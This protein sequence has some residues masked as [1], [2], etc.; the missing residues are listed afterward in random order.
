M[1]IFRR[2]ETLT[3]VFADGGYTG[4]LIGWAKEMF[5][6]AE[7]RGSVFMGSRAAQLH[8]TGNFTLVDELGSVPLSNR[9]PQR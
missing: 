5:G 1:R 8:I 7:A 3:K 9:G 4:T 6:Y 2:Y